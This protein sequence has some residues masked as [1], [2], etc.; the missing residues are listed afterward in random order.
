M[1]ETLIEAHEEKPTNT[2]GALKRKEF[3]AKDLPNLVEIAQF[4][5]DSTI[6]MPADLTTRSNHIDVPEWLATYA[7][8]RVTSE[9]YGSEYQ[10]L[11]TSVL[12]LL[13]LLGEVGRFIFYDDNCE[14]LQGPSYL[15][16]F[17]YPLTDWSGYRSKFE[18][19]GR[20]IKLEKAQV[21][22]HPQF[23][24]IPLSTELE[25]GLKESLRRGR[26]QITLRAW[27]CANDVDIALRATHFSLCR[28]AGR[29]YVDNI[30]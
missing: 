27:D 29:W 26:V 12:V 7:D 23:E 5:E 15:F 6:W 19:V 22:P 21:S 3:R 25:D 9:E 10:D 8:L 13:G 4:R 14:S 20:Y 1:I 18:R 2:L 16:S 24:D 30:E 11:T 17:I 28:V